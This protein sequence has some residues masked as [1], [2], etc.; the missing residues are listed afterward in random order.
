MW[1]WC[2]FW[3]GFAFI[4]FHSILIANH[5]PAELSSIGRIT[6]INVFR[7]GPNAFATALGRNEVINSRTVPLFANRIWPRWPQ[8]FVGGH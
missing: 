3:I 2:V 5:E 7:P 6:D 8:S 1:A 4:Y